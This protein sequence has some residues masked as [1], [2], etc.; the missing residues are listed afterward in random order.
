[1]EITMRT[2]ALIFLFG[3]S[4]NLLAGCANNERMAEVAANSRINAT[5]DEYEGAPDCYPDHPIQPY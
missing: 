2:I 1:M 4:L 3:M 5:C